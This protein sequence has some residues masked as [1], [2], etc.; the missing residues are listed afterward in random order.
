MKHDAQNK[1]ECYNS[2]FH[3]HASAGRKSL[4]H[5][6]SMPENKK[7]QVVLLFGESAR[8]QN[9]SLQTWKHGLEKIPTDN[10]IQVQSEASNTLQDKFNI[11]EVPIQREK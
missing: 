5:V 3:I 7:Y 10:I 4:H 2:C 1:Q 9:R 8:N 11:E 6:T